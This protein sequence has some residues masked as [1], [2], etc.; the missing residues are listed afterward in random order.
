MQWIFYFR[1]VLDPTCLINEACSKY[2]FFFAESRRWKDFKNIGQL[3]QCKYVIN[4]LAKQQKWSQ[5]WLSRKSWSQRCT[6]VIN[7]PTYNVNRIFQIEKSVHSLFINLNLIS[8]S[9]INMLGALTTNYC[10]SR[11]CS[12]CT[13]LTKV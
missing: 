13:E 12:L 6:Y 4:G 5:V 9:K 11:H 10:K 1:P 7:I 3:L 8:I 2:W